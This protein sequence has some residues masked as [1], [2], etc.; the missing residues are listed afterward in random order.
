MEVS[1]WRVGRQR[2]EGV[3][4]GLEVCPAPH[5]DC[6]H[7]LFAACSLVEPVSMFGL[8]PIRASRAAPANVHV[9]VI[10]CRGS[11]LTMGFARQFEAPV[12]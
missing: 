5:H 11:V 10:F 8:L 7:L 3:D 12:T 9:P 6:Y 1:N 2:E 4:R